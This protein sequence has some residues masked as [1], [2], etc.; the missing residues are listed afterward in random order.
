MRWVWIG[1]AVVGVA[2]VGVVAYTEVTMASVETPDYEVVERDGDFE[3]RQYPSMI[4]ASVTVDSTGADARGQGF[5]VLADFIFGNNRPSEKV[6][7]TTPVVQ[8]DSAKIAMTAPVEEVNSDI[9]MTAPGGARGS[10]IS[11]IM[12]AEFTIDTLP[13]PNNPDVSIQERAG[14]RI[15]A[16]RFSGIAS[17]RDMAQK[18]VAL[19]EWMKDQGLTA[20]GPPRYAR[21]DPPWRVPFRRRNEVLIPVR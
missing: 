7:M 8:E 12:P 6:A 9:T 14:E 15:A 19:R 3:V 20:A 17:E 4:L 21:Y 13:A 11:F 1:L 5:R 16:V 2:A 10:T 18:E